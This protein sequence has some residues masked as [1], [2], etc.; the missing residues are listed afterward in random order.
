MPARPKTPID[1][2]AG[3]GSGPNFDVWRAIWHLIYLAEGFWAL[4]T[5]PCSVLSR[6]SGWMDIGGRNG[7]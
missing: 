5:L 4:Q 3:G 7:L 1:M 2:L 6:M